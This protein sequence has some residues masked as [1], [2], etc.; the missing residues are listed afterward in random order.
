MTGSSVLLLDDDDDLRMV[1]CELFSAK[2][3]TCVAAASL[4]ELE[5]IGDAALAC[6]LALLD[7]NLGPGAPSGVDVYRWLGAHS[8]AGRIVFLTGHA[9][10][11]PGVAQARELGAEVLEKPVAVSTLLGLLNHG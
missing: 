10:T 8:Y 7:V 9:R 3:V 2:G 11:F 4:A 6:Q 1:M 5:R